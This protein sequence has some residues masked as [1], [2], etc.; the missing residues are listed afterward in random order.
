LPPPRAAPPLA[1]GG[2]AVFSRRPLAVDTGRGRGGGAARRLLACA[3]R[4]STA[5]TTWRRD[6]GRALAGACPVRGADAAAARFLWNNS[7]KESTADRYDGQWRGFVAYFGAWGV[8]ALPASTAMI[9]T[10][11][12]RLYRSRRIAA[13]SL[14]PI[15]AAMRMRHVA[16]GVSNPC[17]DEEVREAQAGFWRAGLDLRPVHKLQRLPLPAAVAWRLADLTSRSP[18]ARRRHL[19]AVVMQ[20]WWMRRAGDITRLTFGDVDARVDGSTHYKVARHKTEVTTG[21]LARS[22]PRDPGPHLDLPHVLLGRFVI[23]L[24]A[25]GRA[26]SARFFTS[27]APATASAVMT[28]WLRDGLRCLGV[29][30]PVGPCYSSHSLKSG[31]ATAANAIGINRGAI[32]ALSATTEV[33]LAAN[34][35]SALC[36]QSVFDGYFFTSLLPR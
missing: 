21:L 18:S 26:P 1:V 35:I 4:R 24:R 13:I 3:P 20:F 6:L 22:L 11:V 17:D 27:C 7:I 30:P 15:M 33:T 14:K 16:A 31:G 25:A 23:E 8:S 36:I 10:F 12:G 9:V 5:A 32:A 29:T 34:Y 2:A 19:T 28:G